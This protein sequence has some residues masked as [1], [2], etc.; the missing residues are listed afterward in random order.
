M[1][2]FQIISGGASIMSLFI[3]IFVVSKIIKIEKSIHVDGKDNIVTEGNVN[4]SRKTVHKG[5]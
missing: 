1:E 3:S 5:K 4:V 2:L